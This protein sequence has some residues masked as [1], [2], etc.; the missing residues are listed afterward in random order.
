[1]YFIYYFRMTGQAYHKVH[2]LHPHRTQ[3]LPIKPVMS[4]S[5]PQVLWKGI[6]NILEAIW[7]GLHDLKHSPGCPGTNTLPGPRIQPLCWHPHERCG[8]P[9]QRSW[10]WA[11]CGV[12]DALPALPV[13]CQEAGLSRTYNLVLSTRAK[14]EMDTTFQV[15]ICPCRL[16]CR[17]SPSFIH[18]ESPTAERTRSPSSGGVQS[19][20]TV[21]GDSASLK[22]SSPKRQG[23][24][25]GQPQLPC[26]HP[27]SQPGRQGGVCT[28]RRRPR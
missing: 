8:T 20:G 10:V 18:P 9:K 3:P 16:C 7:A 1:M 17:T 22:C 28:E 11:G 14:Q 4:L 23:T 25:Q 26:K 2:K 6:K 5:E 12:G 13:P 15:S 27:G 21:T 24:E 19:P